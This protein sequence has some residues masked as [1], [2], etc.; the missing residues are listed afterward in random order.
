ML[1]HSIL[2]AYL[3]ASLAF[4]VV[5]GLQQR[6]FL[7]VPHGLL[8]VGLTLHTL[9][10]SARLVGQ[11]SQLWWDVYASMGLLAWAMVDVSYCVVALSY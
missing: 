3:F 4:W 6:R 2:L 8:G 7:G 1:F 10:L 9:L 11:A 5:F